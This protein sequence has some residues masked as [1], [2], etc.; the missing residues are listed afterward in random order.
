MDSNTVTAGATVVLAVITG[1]YVYYTHRLL[2]ETQISRKIESIE[3]KLEE[4]Y[5]PFKQ[6]IN[7][8]KMKS[9]NDINIKRFFHN[10]EYMKRLYLC[11]NAHILFILKRVQDP[12][13]I[14]DVKDITDLQEFV[15]KDIDKL[16]KQLKNIQE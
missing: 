10:R 5:Y 4:F 16:I 3:K 6:D 8:C 1:V 11:E 9:S 13:S 15:E 7:F 12:Q 14:I 2:N